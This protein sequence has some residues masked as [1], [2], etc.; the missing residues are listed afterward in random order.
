MGGALVVPSVS[1]FVGH[2]GEASAAR[3]SGSEKARAV[4]F[5]AGGLVKNGG[6]SRW[7]LLSNPLRGDE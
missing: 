1:S 4:Q 2:G 6:M 7:M 3:R 5:E